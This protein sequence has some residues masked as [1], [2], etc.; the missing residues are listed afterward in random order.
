VGGF[1]GCF[2]GFLGGFVG[3]FFVGLLWVFFLYNSFSLFP[4]SIKLL[5]AYK[6]NLFHV[7]VSH[8]FFNPEAY[9][10]VTVCLLTGRD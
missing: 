5:I 3:F 9:R 4:F 10:E 1:F 8:S 2:L 7:T 6:K